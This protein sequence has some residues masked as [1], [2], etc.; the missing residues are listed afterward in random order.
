[1]KT[2]DFK[3]YQAVEVVLDLIATNL[4]KQVTELQRFDF[5]TNGYDF[6]TGEFRFKRLIQEFDFYNKPIEDLK[7]KINVNTINDNVDGFIYVIVPNL[8]VNNPEEISEMKLLFITKGE[9]IKHLE[10]NDY[11]RGYGYISFAV[12]KNKQVTY[13]VLNFNPTQVE[14]PIEKMLKKDIYTKVKYTSNDLSE[15]EKDMDVFKIQNARVIDF[16]EIAKRQTKRMLL[17]ENKK[18]FVYESEGERYRE[19][20]K[21]T[22]NKNSSNLFILDFIE[23]EDL[24]F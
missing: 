8:S 22:G 15:I 4:S 6:R 17:I 20:L 11:S 1:M 13:K 9:I 16:E 18:Y 14:I 7:L 5:H 12:L 19:A 21:K 23:D 2:K 3:N 24:A 10:K